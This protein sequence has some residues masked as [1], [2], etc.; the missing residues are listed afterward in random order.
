MK[1]IEKGIFGVMFMVQTKENVYI[2][3]CMIFER[4]FETEKVLGSKDSKYF[5][6][7]FF[8]YSFRVSGSVNF[9]LN[10]KYFHT[11]QLA[12]ILLN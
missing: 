12:L 3:I 6:F 7:L 2:Y 9:C 10:R 11:R 1:H 8:S 4:L 5:F